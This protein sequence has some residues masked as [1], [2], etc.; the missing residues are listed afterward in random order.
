MKYS[1]GLTQNKVEVYVYLTGSKV[2][3]RLARQPQLLSLAK[4]V[5]SEITLNKPEVCI[6]YDLKRQIGYDFIIKTTDQDSVFYACLVKDKTFTPFIKSG[7]PIP[8]S[9]LTLM[10]RQD[11]DMNY[12]MYDIW[13]GRH[14]PPLPGSTEATDD[15]KPFWLNHA[16]ILGDQTLQ[17]QT[18]T[19]ICPY[20]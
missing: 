2:E 12:E 14:A 15:S 7:D 17:T 11:V 5:L 3:K 8:T 9:Y 6:E 19:K 10:L 18:L 20:Q 16:F 1:V 13:I 4:E